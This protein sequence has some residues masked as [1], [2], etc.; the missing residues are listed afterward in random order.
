MRTNKQSQIVKKIGKV[1]KI[2]TLLIYAAVV[3]LPLLWIILTSLKATQAEIYRFPVQYLP[4]PFSLSNYAEIFSIGNFGQFFFN[5]FFV[6]TTASVCAVFIAI[7]ASYVIA[8]Y[9]FKLR[10]FFLFFFLFTQMIPMFI[11]LGPLYQ[12]MATARMTNRLGTLILLYTS[13]MIPFS[14]VTLRGFFVGIPKS[15]EEAAMIDGCGRLRALFAIVLPIMTPGILATF[16]FAFV[17]SWNELFISVMFIDSEHLKTLPVA[18]NSFIM[19]YDIDWGPLSAGVVVAVI[20][21][22]LM[23][24][25]AQKFMASGLVQGAVKG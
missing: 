19:K 5:S 2:S 12:M 22:I 8:R 21:T 4:K 23:F 17:N 11:M 13:M 7:L 20:P 16:I 1:L 9:T 6:S 24:G 25:Y 15:L 18:L 14:I 10:N 3:I